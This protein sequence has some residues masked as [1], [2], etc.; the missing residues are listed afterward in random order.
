MKVYLLTKVKNLWQKEKLLVLSNLYFCHNSFKSHL[1][2][3]PQNVSLCGKGLNS[4]SAISWCFLDTLPVLSL[5]F[6]PPMKYKLKR[7]P[8]D[9]EL[10]G[11][12][13]FP[14]FLNDPTRD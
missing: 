3:R 9:T 5:L 7:Y 14:P 1:L 8:Q 6:I 11:W 4:I 10:K 13:Q 12:K 2:Q